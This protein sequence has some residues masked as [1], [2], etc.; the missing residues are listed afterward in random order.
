[1]KEDTKP[2]DSRSRDRLREKWMKQVEE[3]MR[4]MKIGK[5]ITSGARSEEVEGH[6]STSSGPLGALYV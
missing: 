4:E 1:M 2:M 6:S 3:D 5:L